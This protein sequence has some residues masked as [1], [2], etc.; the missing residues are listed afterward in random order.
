MTEPRDASFVALLRKIREDVS[1]EDQNL[2]AA[3]RQERI[4]AAVATNPLLSRL[5]AKAEPPDAW[6]AAIQ[7]RR[8]TSKATG[9]GPTPSA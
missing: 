7:R 3:E 5:L 1:A 8:P 4:Q 9:A 2:T 6:A